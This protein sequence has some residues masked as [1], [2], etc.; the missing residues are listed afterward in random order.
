[1]GW[2]VSREREKADRDSSVSGDVSGAPG[3]EPFAKKV[4]K[5][6]GHAYKSREGEGIAQRAAE[7]KSQRF[8]LCS[9]N[10]EQLRVS[11]PAPKKAELGHQERKGSSRSGPGLRAFSCRSAPEAIL[12]LP[13]PIA[14]AVELRGPQLR[15]VAAASPVASPAGPGEPRR[16]PRRQMRHVWVTPSSLRPDTGSACAVQVLRDPLLLYLHLLRFPHCSPPSP[17]F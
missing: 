6:N 17:L 16:R 4:L 5:V 14:P 7:E 15:F 12:P 3:T 9:G 13:T 11:P 1:M 8:A 10:Q 2:A